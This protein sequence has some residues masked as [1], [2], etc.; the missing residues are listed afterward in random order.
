M[1]RS[2]ISKFRAAIRLQFD[3]HRAI[4]NLG[5]SQRITFFSLL[6]GERKW[7]NGD[8]VKTK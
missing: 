6:D 3:F 7:L 1:A 2:A 8:M 5:V 4:Y